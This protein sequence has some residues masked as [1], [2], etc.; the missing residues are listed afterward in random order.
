MPLLNDM[1][2]VFLSSNRKELFLSKYWVALNKKN[3]EQLEKYGYDNFKRTI[4]LNYFT[5]LVSP[6][7]EQ[8][9]YLAGNLPAR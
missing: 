3:M 7:D 9:K 2:E 6:W 1:F 4:A 5:W 8:I